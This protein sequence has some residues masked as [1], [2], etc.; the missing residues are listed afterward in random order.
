MV[1]AII[2][3]VNMQL[4]SYQR[5]NSLFLMIEYSHQPFFD[6]N[7]REDVWPIERERSLI[8]G[9]AY[10][11]MLEVIHPDVASVINNRA[12]FT[13]DRL[14]RTL[15]GNTEIIF[16]TRE[17][18]IKRAAIVNNA[19]QS[20][21]ANVSE[22]KLFVFEM[23]VFGAIK[24]YETFVETLSEQQ[25][26][27]Y[28]KGIRKYGLVLGVPMGKTAISYS[29]LSLRIKDY[30]DQFS[31]A[32]TT[33]ARSIMS[34]LLRPFYVSDDAVKQLFNSTNLISRAGYSSMR[35]LANE[36]NCIVTKGLMGEQV[37]G[38]YGLGWNKVE[39]TVFCIFTDIVQN[40][41]S[42]IPPKFRYHDEYQRWV[43]P[44]DI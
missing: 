34:K 2:Q 32:D 4:G 15:Q 6:K 5:K 22:L 30:I 8:F 16:G 11:L 7:E 26:N 40:L 14:N 44:I 9:R 23:R 1:V 37:R 21:G 33:N 42:K 12:T 43:R 41:S 25:K 24:T 31:N 38:L 13:F 29:D 20:N 39:N 17:E 18:A 3:L 28:V 27:D 35:H 19:H 36:M 10:R